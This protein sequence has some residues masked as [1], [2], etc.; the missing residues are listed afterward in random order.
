MG[1]HGVRARDRRI[2]TGRIDALGNLAVDVDSVVQ[3]VIDRYARQNRGRGVDKELIR[4]RVEIGH[5]LGLVPALERNRRTVR[6]V[7]A[8]VREYRSVL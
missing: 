6:N 5:V 4:N 1:S 7:V 2:D 3:G 8:Q